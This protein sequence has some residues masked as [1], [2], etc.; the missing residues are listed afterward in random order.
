M[1]L[2]EVD[3]LKAGYGDLTVV[4]GIDLTVDRG[5]MLT[6]IGPNGAGKS[7]F[8]KGIVGL[9]DRK[10]GSVVLDGVEVTH[11][12]PEEVIYEGICHVPQVDNV[13]P[14]LSVLE[15]LKMGAWA[16]EDATFEE[17]V[18]A[19]Y[20]RFPVL[21]DR[22]DQKAG[23][24]SGGQQQMVAM[25][26]ALMLDPDLLILD[27]PS[28]G[29]APQLVDDVFKKIVEINNQEGTAVLMVEQNARR[30]LEESN[31]GIVLDLGEKEM[32]GSGAQLLDSNE[33]Q[34]LYLGT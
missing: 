13:F 23:T 20:D 9:A 28:A 16:L 19:V 27:E 14:N 17:R 4:H 34:E 2:L 29:L 6:I 10:G 18:Q 22:P 24:L 32:E 26:A 11:V 1:S 31:R 21:K 5:E 30:A 25:G 15:N 12:P 33:V 8:L 3:G 7:T